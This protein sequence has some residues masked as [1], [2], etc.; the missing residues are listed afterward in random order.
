MKQR[1]LNILSFCNLL[2][3]EGKLSLTNVGLVVLLIRVGM[4]AQLDWA[5]VTTLAL[6]FANYMHKRKESSAA[7]Q[8]SESEAMTK[9]KSQYEAAVVAQASAIKDLND[10][11]KQV[12]DAVKIVDLSKLKLR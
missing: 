8:A 11:L 3:L 10:K 4:A 2:D 12:S 9:I 1:L 7:E 6:A 5:S